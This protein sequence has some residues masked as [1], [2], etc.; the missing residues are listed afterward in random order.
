LALTV[1]EES[2]LRHSKRRYRYRT[3]LQN[4][5]QSLPPECP[6][7]TSPTTIDSIALELLTEEAAESI[8]APLVE[9]VG[10]QVAARRRAD[11]LPAPLMA[12]MALAR[13]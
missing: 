8:R 12:C 11:D 13:L 1:S 10:T 4:R 6:R 2:T 7:Q 9:A 3:A 5:T